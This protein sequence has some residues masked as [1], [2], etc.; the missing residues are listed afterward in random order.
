MNN[1]KEDINIKGDYS[2]A[3]I[4][5]LST[6]TILYNKCHLEKY[7]E[8]V[9]YGE[10]VVGDVLDSIRDLLLKL[11]YNVY[12][13]GVGDIRHPI[14]A[15][16]YQWYMDDE[17]LPLVNAYVLAQFANDVYLVLCQNSD[18]TKLTDIADEL[19]EVYKNH[20]E[21]YSVILAGIE[22]YDSFYGVNVPRFYNS[23][24]QIANKRKT[25]SLREI[26]VF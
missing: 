25:D 12:N 5:E 10:D 1:V 9:D 11:Y 4:S 24:K 3:D 8:Q 19:K 18:K 2:E 7:L 13:V 26:D 20:D 21:L 14:I 17:G 6:D 23:C 15:F 16:K 22:S